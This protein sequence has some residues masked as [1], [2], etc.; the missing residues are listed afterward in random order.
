MSLED[1]LI[2]LVLAMVAKYPALSAVLLIIGGLR[3]FLRPLVAVVRAYVSYTP[4]PE[5]NIWLDRFEGSKF[6]KGLNFMLDLIMSIKIKP[7]Q[8]K[9]EVAE[10]KAE[11]K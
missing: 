7:V 9:D 2:S 1:A 11:I 6:Y 4:Q 8:R 10:V 3:V 5:D